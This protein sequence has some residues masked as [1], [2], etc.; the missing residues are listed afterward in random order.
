M[1]C[2]VQEQEFFFWIRRPEFFVMYAVMLFL[3]GLGTGTYSHDYDRLKLESQFFLM[4]SGLG[5]Y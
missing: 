3:I 4:G 2:T 5:L 1:S